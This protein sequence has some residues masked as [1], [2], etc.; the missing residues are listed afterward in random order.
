MM[1]AQ[2][3]GEA[4]AALVTSGIVVV[5][6]STRSASFRALAA[7][8]PGEFLK[9]H[10]ATMSSADREALGKMLKDRPDLDFSY[11]RAPGKLARAVEMKEVRLVTGC[12]DAPPRAHGAALGGP[13]ARFR[14][15][16]ARCTCC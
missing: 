16:R 11:F 7:E 3:A 2:A 4:E 1:A 6:W 12:T 15:P 9:N 10:G 14:P 5:S 8:G 13:I